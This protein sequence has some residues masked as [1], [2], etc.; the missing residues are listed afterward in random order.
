MNG[1][2]FL[3]GKEKEEGTKESTFPFF[4]FLCDKIIKT[5]E[6]KGGRYDERGEE[7]GR[8]LV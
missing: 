7:G 4:F 3:L 5:E 6:E 2:F 1:F 8:F